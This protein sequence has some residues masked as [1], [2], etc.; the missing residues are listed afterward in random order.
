MLD[1]MTG[2]WKARAEKSEFHG[3]AVGEMTRDELLALIGF[4]LQCIE[5]NNQTWETAIMAM[6][7]ALGEA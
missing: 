6:E 4:L 3:Q 2:K 5:K 7:K 1:G